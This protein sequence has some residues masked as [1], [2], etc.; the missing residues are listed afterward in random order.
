MTQ[1][2]GTVKREVIGGS[3]VLYILRCGDGSLYTGITNNLAHR[4]A[5]H[6]K[7][8]ASRYTRGRGPLQIVYGKACRGRSEALKMELAVKALSRTEKEALI[9]S[10]K[11][12]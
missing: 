1:K 6:Q 5:E 11:L 4:F 10:E 3:W 12:N 8:R 9:G 7:G 2:P